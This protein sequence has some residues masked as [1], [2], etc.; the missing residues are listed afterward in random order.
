ML[1]NS[2]EFIFAFLP[3]VLAGFFLAAR[4]AGRQPAL[5]FL[6]L[7]SMF[8]YAWWNP[9]YLLLLVGEVCANFAIGR[10]ILRYRDQPRGRQIL[11]AGLVFNLLILGYFKYTLFFVGIL[12][13]LAGTNW[14]LVKLVLPLGISFHTFQQ[15]AYLIQV[16]SG[17]APR[18][19]FWDYV[20]FVTFFPQLIAGPIVHHNEVIPQIAAPGFTTWRRENLALGMSIFAIGLFK[21][22]VIADALAQIAT[23]AFTLAA[24]GGHLST[25]DA[26]LGAI[27]YTLQLYFDFSAYSDMA[28]GLARMFNITLPAN[29]DSP[30]KARNIADFWRR[31][32]MTLSRFLR[33]YLYFPLGGNRLGPVRAMAN[34]MITM[35]LGGLWHGAGWTFVVWGGL[36]GTYIVAHRLILASGMFERLVPV[37]ALRHLIGQASTLFLVIVAWVFFRAADFPTAWSVLGSMFGISSGAAVEAQFGVGRPMLLVGVTAC[38]ALFAPNVIDIFAEQRPVLE[39]DRHNERRLNPLLRRL[40]WNAGPAWGAAA[41]ALA[42]LGI[43]AILG[44]QSEFLYFQF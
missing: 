39:I 17:Q 25:A 40:R 37:P 14:S 32:H 41:G 6:A 5:V 33:Q 44:W 30:Y 43:V 20:L 36:H 26:W 31:W 9:L 42:S 28:I 19:R 35:L 23:P 1:F 12:N 10:V 18:Y 24:Q 16:R 27:G 8:F 11:I 34:V 22:T 13:D 29:F 7:A 2:F 3:L 38:I 21:K 15:I 4:F